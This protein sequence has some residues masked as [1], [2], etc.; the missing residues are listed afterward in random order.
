L[1]YP[2]RI[3]YYN[4]DQSIEKS[5]TVKRD[6]AGQ[7]LAYCDTELVSGSTC[8]TG[9]PNSPVY[10]NYYDALG[11]TYGI[12]NYYLKD[13]SGNPLEMHYDFDAF[14]NRKELE[15]TRSTNT[16]LHFDYSYDGLDRLT[17]ITDS[18]QSGA[19]IGFGYGSSSKLEEIRQMNG[20]KTE[21]SYASSTTGLLTGIEH[22]RPD[23]SVIMA[24]AYSY[25]SVNNIPTRQLAAH[26]R[27]ILM[28]PNRS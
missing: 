28:M 23:N 12:D 6:K 27:T 26:L 24:L 22:L 8:L 21:F 3:T 11:R 16:L 14:G 25:N 4:A 10:V 7:I 17:R 18:V 2:Q 20:S 9:T 15:V 5:R 1:A 19:T 13:T